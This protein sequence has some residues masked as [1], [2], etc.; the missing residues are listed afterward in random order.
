MIPKQKRAVAL[1]AGPDIRPAVVRLHCKIVKRCA[2][3]KGPA[4]LVLKGEVN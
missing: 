4:G 3:F 1:C 2:H